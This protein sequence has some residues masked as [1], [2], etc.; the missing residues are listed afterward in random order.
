MK[1]FKKIALV[2]GTAVAISGATVASA[3]ET[4]LPDQPEQPTPTIC[5]FN[6]GPQIDLESI[7]ESF[8]MTVEELQAALDEGQTI[9]DIADE[10]GVDL[11]APADR[12]NGPQ[13]GQTD[14][15]NENLPPFLNQNQNQNQNVDECPDAETRLAEL[16][17]LLDMTVEDLQAALDEGQTIRDIADE[18]GVELPQPPRGPQGQFG[19]QNGQPNNQQPPTN[20]NGQPNGQQ[21]P[22]QGNQN[23]QPNTQQQPPANQNGQPNGQQQP[24]QGNQNGQSGTQ[25]P[26]PGNGGPQGPG[27]QN[28]PAGPPTG[29]QDNAPQGGPQGP[30]RPA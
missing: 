30:Q 19:N 15:Q 24:P 29:P 2:L 8:D 3:Q 16:A 12:G 1:N 20:Q 23:G 13:L 14:P 9:R 22:P 5:Q 7:A 11:P 27:N 4:G 25:P 6:F 18:L 17:D 28:A 10:L 21:Q 26:V